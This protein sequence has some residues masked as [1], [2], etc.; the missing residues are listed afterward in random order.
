MKPENPVVWFEI[1]VDDLKRAQ[2]FYEAVFNL[3]MS[4]MPMPDT[5][6]EMEMLFFPSD[7]ESKNRASGAL[8]K[9]EGFSA[10]NN[11]TIVYFMSD[12][13]SIEEAR[14]ESAGGKIFK[15]KMS[16]GE[17]GFMVLATDTEG[18]MIGIHSM[19]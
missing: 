15:S 18:N 1:Y 8:V 9:M 4:E 5:G 3:K 13:C 14:V 17:Y 12:D 16:L 6:E 11:S 10:G 7:P 19:E 2:K